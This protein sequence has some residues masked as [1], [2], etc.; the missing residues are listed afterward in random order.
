LKKP[1]VTLNAP[2]CNAALQTLDC[3]WYCPIPYIF[4]LSSLHYDGHDIL[5]F[6]PISAFDN[7][8]L[9]FNVLSHFNVI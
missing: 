5:N 9:L 7:I 6:I 3:I 8:L 4:R 2:E 1:P